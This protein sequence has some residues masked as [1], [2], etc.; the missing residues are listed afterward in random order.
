MKRIPM[1]T[2]RILVLI[3]TVVVIIDDHFWLD[4]VITRCQFFGLAVVLC[5]AVLVIISSRKN[6]RSP[7]I[8]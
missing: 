7:A 1:W 5:G 8:G 3:E 6:G 2:F 4:T